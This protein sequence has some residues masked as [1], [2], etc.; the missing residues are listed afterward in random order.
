MDILWYER[1]DE[2]IRDERS[3]DAKFHK[4]LL[5]LFKRMEAIKQSRLDTTVFPVAV[6]AFDAKADIVSP[7]LSLL[8]MIARDV[9]RR[10][11]EEPR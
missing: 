8:A 11:A 3:H 2:S 5:A 6:L 10:N 9:V 7:T 4:E 1:R